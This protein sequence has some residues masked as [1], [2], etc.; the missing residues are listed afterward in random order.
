M[1]G[2]EGLSVL[3]YGKFGDEYIEDTNNLL[4]LIYET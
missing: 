2:I 1:L 3:D 4:S